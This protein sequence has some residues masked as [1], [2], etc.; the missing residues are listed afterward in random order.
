MGYDARSVANWFVRRA[1]KDNR[2]LTIMQLLKLIYIAHG[3]RLAMKG[4]PLFHNRIEAWQYG[5]VIPEVYSS[6]RPQGIHIKEPIEVDGEDLSPED[7][8]FLEEIYD[9]YGNMSPFRLSELTHES[10]GP[11]EIA[12]QKGGYYALIPDSLI[13]RHY[14]DKLVKSE[15]TK[16]G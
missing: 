13:R 12:S 15:S 9:I 11:W 3:W 8:S 2:I 10:G 7:E 4:A 5:P 6:F 1:R 16:D 14:Q